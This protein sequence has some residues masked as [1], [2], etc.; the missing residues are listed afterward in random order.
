MPRPHLSRPA[1]VRRSAA[2]P[3]PPRPSLAVLGDLILDV[4]VAPERPLE[5]GTDVPGTLRFRAG[6]SAA[7]VARSFAHLGGASAFIGSVGR[8]GWGSRLAAVLRAEGVTPHVVVSGPVTGRLAAVVDRSGERSFITERGSADALRPD[9]LRAAWLRRIGALHVPAYSL[10]HDPVA[11][12]AI[13]AAGLAH[14]ARALVTVDTASRAPLL[15]F[16]RAAA[17][18]RIAAMAPDVLF[19]NRGEAAALAGVAAA[20]AP[21]RLLEL[22]PVVVVKDGAAGCDVVWREGAAGAVGAAGSSAGGTAGGVAELE[23]AASPIAAAD[24]TGAGDAFAAGFLFAL[25][26]GGA[27]AVPARPWTA[28]TLRRAALAG[29]RSAADLLRRPRAELGL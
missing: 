7:N 23:I 11:T 15:A 3:K 25:L 28:A 20:R 29:H 4:V 6:G 17:W 26:G 18:E 22:A 27:S 2:P 16:G 21:R 8:D 10:F 19:A 9:D 12:A 13:R 24:T 5:H 14:E 1:G